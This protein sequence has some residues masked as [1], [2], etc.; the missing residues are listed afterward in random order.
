[1]DI[2]GVG[3]VVTA[4]LVAFG[5]ACATSPQRGAGDDPPGIASVEESG[6]AVRVAILADP[7]VVPDGVEARLGLAGAASAWRPS[8]RLR[9][10]T[11]RYA[12]ASPPKN[13]PKDDSPSQNRSSTSG[14]RNTRPGW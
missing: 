12:A 11:N 7:Q 14:S 2:E 10:L 5:G 8:G 9:R 13:P 3:G 6:V 4:G 1:M